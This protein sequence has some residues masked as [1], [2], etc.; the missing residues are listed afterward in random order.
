[1]RADNAK[2]ATTN[3]KHPAAKKYDIP[4]Y[5]I[6]ESTKSYKEN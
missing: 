6:R 5:T 2:W 4:E 1:M 3:G